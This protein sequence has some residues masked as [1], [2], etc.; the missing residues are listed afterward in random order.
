ME[1][2]KKTLKDVFD[3]STVTKVVFVRKDGKLAMVRK[4]VKALTLTKGL[5]PMFPI[6]KERK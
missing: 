5:K 1:R 4:T 3:D 6:S 2:R